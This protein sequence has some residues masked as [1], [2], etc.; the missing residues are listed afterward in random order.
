MGR[1]ISRVHRVVHDSLQAPLPS[2][3]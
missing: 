1:A 3:C 2:P